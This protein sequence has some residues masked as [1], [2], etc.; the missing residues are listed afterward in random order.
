MTSIPA[1]NPAEDE[2]RL[3]D[4]GTAK[5]LVMAEFVRLIEEGRAAM[6]TLEAGTLE[7]RLATGEIFHLGEET[8]T[9]IA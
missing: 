6:L 7:I 1:S 9:R 4:P 5:A 8:V 2:R 3:D